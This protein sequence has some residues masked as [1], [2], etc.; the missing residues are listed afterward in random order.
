[1]V[2]L[3]MTVCGTQAADYLVYSVVGNVK[4]LSGNNITTLTSRT[5][6]KAKARI[7]IG[8]ESALTILDE[9]NCKMYSFTEQGTNSLE[10]MLKESKRGKSLSRQYV[11]YMVKNLFSKEGKRLSHP[12]NYMQATATSYRATT[13]DSLLLNF[14]AKSIP[15]QEGGSI[16]EAIIEKYNSISSDLNVWFELVSYDTE[17]PLDT[18]VKEETSCYV[19]VHNDSNIPLYV[20]ILNIDDFGEKYLVLPVDDAAICAHLLVP[21]ESTVGFISEP[22][23]FTNTSSSETFLLVATE[24]PV[25]FSILMNP[26]HAS[27]NKTIRTGLYRVRYETM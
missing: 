11:S 5:S 23:E 3:I 17:E 25:D 13:I 26:I 22:F 15:T 2:V 20:N 27:G 21:A 16:E 14:L 1:M 24:E 6:L 9:R 10:N 7:I 18:S 4:V 12:S 19:R 8:K